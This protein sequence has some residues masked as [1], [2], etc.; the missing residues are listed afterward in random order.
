M[1]LSFK[2][3]LISELVLLVAVLV[4]V[5]P[6]WLAM[7]DQIVMNMQTELKAIASTLRPVLELLEQGGSAF[8]ILLELHLE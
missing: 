6:V 4:L 5:V 2:L 3:L 8:G 1:R 7:R